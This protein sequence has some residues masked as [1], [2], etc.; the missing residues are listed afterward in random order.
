MIQHLR[1][2]NFAIIDHLEISFAPGLNIITGETGAGKSIIIG[3]FSLLLGN[4]AQ[5]DLVKPGAEE[6]VLEAM[7]NLPNDEELLIRRTIS[8]TGKGKIQ[9]N[10]Q[11]ATM[12]Q[13]QE[14]VAPLVE[15]CSQHEHQ[16]LL[17]PSYH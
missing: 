4:R 1:I 17:N 9:L 7:F 6:A 8:A 16:K 5:S 2:A 12:G 3:A 15:M 10:G 14:V 11:L 13:L